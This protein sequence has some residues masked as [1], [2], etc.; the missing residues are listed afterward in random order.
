[1]ENPSYYSDDEIILVS[2]AI[3]AILL[4]GGDSKS[5]LLSSSFL[6][7]TKP[8]WKHLLITSP[9]HVIGFLRDYEDSS[10]GDSEGGG[11]MEF[12]ISLLT[13]DDQLISSSSSSLSTLLQELI[14]SNSNHNLLISLIFHSNNQISDILDQ[15]E[16]MRDGCSFPIICHFLS[17]FLSHPRFR[18]EMED[19]S[20]S[21]MILVQFMLSTLKFLFFESIPSHIL[22]LE[23]FRL[24][25]S[26]L[27][28]EGRMEDQDELE[29]E[30]IQ[31]QEEAKN[32]SDQT[33]N[34]ESRSY[35]GN[36]IYSALSSIKLSIEMS[37]ELLGLQ[38][39][40][41][42]IEKSNLINDTNEDIV[43][44]RRHIELHD[45][46]IE[47][48]IPKEGGQCWMVQCLEDILLVSSYE[49]RN[50][51]V[52]NWISLMGCILIHSPSSPVLSLQLLSSITS[53]NDFL[54]PIF[55][56]LCY[57]STFESFVRSDLWNLVMT[58]E[59]EES[60][61]SF[62]NLIMFS[63]LLSHYLMS[64]DDFEIFEKGYPLDCDSF[65]EFIPKLVS[66]IQTEIIN[67]LS[68]FL[69]FPNQSS[70]PSSCSYFSAS[71]SSSFVSSPIS[72][73]FNNPSSYQNKNHRSRKSKENEDLYHVQTPTY[74]SPISFDSVNFLSSQEENEEKSSSFNSDSP[75]QQDG[76]REGW[77]DQCL[78]RS[79]FIISRLL[80]KV[81]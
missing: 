8:S 20:D 7:L 72:M 25:I 16:M 81:F 17:H 49:N 68:H 54:M 6:Q 23:L 22:T 37:G 51:K 66:N 59:E 56:T 45:L 71:Y 63:S 62:L 73:M 50:S 32:S 41:F 36:L 11:V 12:L 21:M 53:Y 70:S 47:L 26:S 15:L 64:L 10:D 48:L 13:K 28:E 75:F 77:K 58:I 33:N 46:L 31:D 76:R 19:K 52:Q 39:I 9:Y 65:R 42:E 57:S 44:I 40:E 80:S 27:K 61:D 4:L 2:W 35:L 43:I 18:Q 38:E 3:G 29:E 78:F 55:N 69:S 74:F 30:W 1:M 14:T 67:Y 79:F 60:T 34:K 5:S 24:S